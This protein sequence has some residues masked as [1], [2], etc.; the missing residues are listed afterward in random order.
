MSDKY[1]GMTINERL[2]ACD[3]INE[4]DQAVE[5]KDVEKIKTILKEVEVDEASI[6]AII[7]EYELK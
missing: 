3:K 4:F 7:K 1:L 2:Y 5:E 6:Q